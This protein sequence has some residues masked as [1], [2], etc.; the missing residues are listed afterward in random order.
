E[1]RT[2]VGGVETLDY[3]DAGHLFPG[4]ARSALPR[5]TKHT[6]KPG[7]EQPDM[8]T[9]YAYT[10]NNFLGRGSGVTWRDNGEDNLY[11]FTGTDFS[12]GSTANHLVG[13]TPLRSVTRTFNRF[14]L[15]TLQVTEQA[16]EVYDEHNTQPRRETCL[17]ELETVYHET[18]ASFQLQPSYFQLPKHQLKRWKIKENASRLREEVLIT[19]YDEHGNLALESKAAAPV[20]KGDAIDE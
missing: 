4:D 10:S 18:G 15:L 14:H 2:P 12:Y 13:T 3:D 20:Y 8:V 11:Q 1:V 16:H 17:Q 19:H 5:V 9:T 7:A 6:I